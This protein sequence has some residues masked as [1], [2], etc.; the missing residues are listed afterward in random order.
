MENIEPLTRDLP[1]PESAERFFAEISSKHPRETKK[2]VRDRSLL[3]DILTIAAYSPLL[4]TTVLQNPSY[5][6]WLA[7]EKR[8][9]KVRD[10]EQ[11]LESL[12]RFDLINTSVD[13]A[14]MLS[15][16]R[17][18]ELIRIFLKDIRGLGTIA[19]LTE[20]IS[21]LADS[22]LEHALRTSIQE[23]DNRFGMPLETDQNKKSSRAQFCVVALG[24][25]GSKELNYSSDIDLLFL[26]SSDGSTSGQGSRGKTSNKEYFVKLAEHVSRVV[27]EPKG[28]G[29]A[30]R[31][32]HRLRP[33][34]RVG[35]LAVSL[36]EAIAYYR[37]S[38]QLWEKQVLIRSRNSAGDEGLFQ[39]FYDS[40]EAYVF[41]PDETVENALANVLRSK[42]KIDLEKIRSQGYDVKL[43]MGGI[44][45]IEFIAQALQL[46]FGAEDKWLRA[47]H[48]L[49]S[50]S[51]LADRGLISENE[52]TRLSEAY[53][54]LRK[55]EHRLQMEHGLQTHLI[56]NE[57]GRQELVA[58]RCGFE[59]S[60]GFRSKLAKHVGNVSRI[61]KRFFDQTEY[62]EISHSRDAETKKAPPSKRKR[63]Y[64]E[65][66]ASLVSADTNVRDVMER[67][68]LYARPFAPLLRASGLRINEIP[69]CSD[70]WEWS[71]PE[72]EM[73]DAV[74]EAS[75]DFKEM[76]AGIRTNWSRLMLEIVV[77]DV[78]ANAGLR[79]VKSR[80]TSLAEASIAAAVE[81]TEH[82]LEE[83]FGSLECG[84]A[85]NVIGLGKLGGGG[86]DY[87]SD[88]DLLIVFD[89]KAPSPAGNKTH[90]EFYSKAVE[91]FVTALSSLTREGSLYK[92]D[93]RLRPDGRNGATAIGKTALYEYFEDR[94]AIWEWLAYVKARSVFCSGL[95]LGET[96]TEL[97]KIIH[98]NAAEAEQKVLRDATWKIRH[99]LET[100][101]SEGR[102]GRSI[103]LKYGEGGLQDVYFAVRYLQLSAGVPD[104]EQDR[105]TG[106]T[107]DRLLERRAIGAREHESLSHGYGFLS[108]LDH[109]IRLSLGRSTLVPLGKLPV[110]ELIAERMK[111]SNPADLLEQLSYHRIAVRDAFESI[112][113]P[114]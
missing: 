10:K 108:R 67:L 90:A 48:T 68:D 26:Y 1:D 29:G 21:N 51:R 85:W 105:S 113:L 110:L 64:S 57:S 92:V 58:R 87:H 76:L 86:M 41:S 35:A 30:Y 32:D 96:D 91:I 95:E 42:Q 103:D 107:L 36:K 77:A 98:G 54:F 101:K 39:M 24:K 111:C 2:L 46:A 33:H 44:R 13:P 20:E 71:D 52:F 31:V 16:F 65:D 99:R 59:D 11:L 18:R 55:V 73:R 43:G 4:S 49:I 69:R 63:E 5:I 79:E 50:L 47:P 80:Q 34:G 7:R 100:E 14:V 12:A 93:L 83:V 88:L 112:L 40:V 97:R 82:R 109:N 102:R 9:Q 23:L 25:L 3:S 60:A 38:A 106:G 89:D 8:D 22:I 37:D 94:S 84:V 81:I 72:L 66:P 104:D 19:E 61:F 45:E 17:R 56:P 75:G 6:R 114:G 62:V 70:K 28:E 15:R 78:C 27:S 53:G 74:G